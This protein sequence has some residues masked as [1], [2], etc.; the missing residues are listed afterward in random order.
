MTPPRTLAS[1]ALGAVAA[2]STLALMLALLGA[3]TGCATVGGPTRAA[4]SAVASMASGLAEVDRELAGRYRAAAAESLT[5]AHTSDEYEDRMRR[6]NAAESSLRSAH[7]ALLGA[8]AAIDAW[9]HSASDRDWRRAA[10]CVA[11]AIGR[12]GTALR[13]AGVP[14]P[15]ALVEALTTATQAGGLCGVPPSSAPAEEAPR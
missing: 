1:H 12:L 7:E 15:S 9:E 5:I 3:A 14:M 2:A 8:E 6:W 13:A 11:E 4:R 10:P